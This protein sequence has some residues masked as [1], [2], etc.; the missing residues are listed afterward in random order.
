MRCSTLRRRFLASDEAV[1]SCCALCGA[2]PP[3]PQIYGL[4][5]VMLFRDGEMVEGSKREGAITK[6]K[7]IAHL[8]TFRIDKPAPAA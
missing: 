2:H 8:A 7:L 4:P 6:D 1:N 5:T 3:L